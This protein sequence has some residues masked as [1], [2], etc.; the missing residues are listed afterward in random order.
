MKVKGKILYC[1]ALISI[2]VFTHMASGETLPSSKQQ[3]SALKNQVL[4]AKPLE[5][6]ILGMV[7]LNSGNFRHYCVFE[8][9]VEALESKMKANITIKLYPLRAA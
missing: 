3:S 6:I 7:D 2:L 5:E 4:A 8:K 1:F 9:L